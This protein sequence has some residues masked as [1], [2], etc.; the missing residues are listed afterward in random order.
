MYYKPAIMF[1]LAKHELFRLRGEYK[2]TKVWYKP[3]VKSAAPELFLI[4]LDEVCSK[5]SVYNPLDVQE[6]KENIKIPKK[7]AKNLK[8]AK[9]E[10]LFES[11]VTD[12]VQISKDYAI[13]LTKVKCLYKKYK[14]G[15]SLATTHSKPCKIKKI[16][17]DSIETFLTDPENV[18]STTT[19]IKNHLLQH[20]EFED[21][22][23]S[24][25][26][27]TK[28]LDKLNFSRKKV[29]HII[30]RQNTRRQKRGGG[31]LFQRW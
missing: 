7:F 27:V 22:K 13:K 2:I 10:V 25:S 8:Q 12:L 9:L 26:T 6:T 15:K 1:M 24:L 17:L 14:E 30:E 28:A 20:F 16:H 11:G 19:E 21:N 23:L 31:K 18:T 4:Y 3:F 29:T 5:R